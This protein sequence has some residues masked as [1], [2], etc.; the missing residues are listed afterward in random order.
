[1][2][3]T[4][5]QSSRA[6]RLLVASITLLTPSDTAELDPDTNL[7]FCTARGGPTSHTAI[8][9]R[10]LGIPAIVGAGEAVL[11]IADGTLSILDGSSGQLY[12]KPT[13][14]DVKSARE[15]QKQSQRDQDVANSNRFAPATTTDGHRI[16]IAANINRAADAQPAIAAK[17]EGV[18]L[19]RTEF[20]FLSRDTAPTEDEQFEAYRAMV[21]ALEGRTLVIRTLNIGGDKEVPY[22]NLPKEDNSFL[23]IRGIR[24]CLVRPDLF[25][26]QL[27]AIYRAAAYMIPFVVTNLPL[28]ALSIVI[29]TLVTAGALFILKRPVAV[30][31]ESV[32]EVPVAAVA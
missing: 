12:L 8:I 14:S 29:G 28:Y 7:G 11:T 1:V 19:M 20:L 25:I 26:P 2:L 30:E 16:E 32:E 21:Q 5:D 3:L 17:A 4:G 22:L 15:M 18:G 13:E 23:G 27:R 31:E 24:L 10:S 9:A 6:Q